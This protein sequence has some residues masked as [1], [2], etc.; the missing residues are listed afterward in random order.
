M[1]PTES[2]RQLL[3]IRAD[4]VHFATLGIASPIKRQVAKPAASIQE[5]A[6]LSW[7][8]PAVLTT[9]IHPEMLDSQIF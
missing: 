3:S 8:N 5:F 9:A 1:H 2:S 7:R 4:S 6:S